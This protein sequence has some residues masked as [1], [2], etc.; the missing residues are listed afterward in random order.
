[1]IFE[2]I[3]KWNSKCIESKINFFGIV[4]RLVEMLNVC[5]LCVKQ[6]HNFC[7]QLAEPI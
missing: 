1:M 5:F 6:C 3:E 7:V 4:I 2:R